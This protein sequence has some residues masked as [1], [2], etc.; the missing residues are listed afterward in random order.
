LSA[1]NV[2]RHPTAEGCSQP[3]VFWPLHQ[4]DECEQNT[5]DR[6]DRK[7]DGNDNTQPHKGGNMVCCLPVVKL[8]RKEPTSA[9]PPL[10]MNLSGN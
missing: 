3:F 1:K 6:E 9:R 10:R 7:Q 4:H 2:F 5:D 8:L